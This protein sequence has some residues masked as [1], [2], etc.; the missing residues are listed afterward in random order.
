[1]PDTAAT[2]KVVFGKPLQLD[3]AR[4]DADLIAAVRRGKIEAFGE[5]Y[6][7]H[8]TAASFLARRLSGSHA[9]AEDLVQEAF[10]KILD[11]LRDGKG[12]DS[13][14]RSYLL[15]TLRHCAYD[16]ARKHKKVEPIG[17]FSD[18]L[19]Y[20]DE[21][22]VHFR[23]T[24]LANLE[25]R[26]AAKAFALLPDRWRTVLLLREIKQLTPAE[27]A[28]LMSLTSENVSALLYR[29]RRGLRDAFLQVH[30][31]RA[32]GDT[33]CQDVVDNLGKWTRGHLNSQESDKVESHLDHCARCTALAREFADLNVGIP[34]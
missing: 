32:A 17:D 12:P 18:R 23:D 14:F 9:V 27:I 16:H 8:E 7:R 25:E 11:L 10:E 30:A 20:R 2:A 29:A 5:L 4:G 19:G 15:T 24:E 22:V 6:A 26:L 13:A 28:P 3:K 31:E 1:M 33:Q 21:L 34:A